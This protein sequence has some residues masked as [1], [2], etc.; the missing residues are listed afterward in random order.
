MISQCYQLKKAIAKGIPNLKINFENSKAGRSLSDISACLA[1]QT[2][3]SQIHII[4][5][6]LAAELFRPN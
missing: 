6:S 4:K 2:I 3:L 1:K 5:W